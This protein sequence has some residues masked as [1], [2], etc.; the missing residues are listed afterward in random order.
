MELDLPR[1][2]FCRDGTRRSQG[3]SLSGLSSTVQG[4]KIKSRRGGTRHSRG[5]TL[6]RVRIYGIQAR[7]RPKICSLFLENVTS[8]IVRLR[9]WRPGRHSLMPVL[10]RVEITVLFQA[11]DLNATR[12]I[13]MCCCR[14]IRFS[15]I[16]ARS[17]PSMLSN[18][19]S[20]SRRGPS[21]MDT[22]SPAENN[23]L[24]STQ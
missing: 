15:R 23:D 12:G 16:T 19:A 17:S 11:M 20:R 22:G 10:Y 7:Y 21:L 1:G 5:A 8:H 3:Q 18:I 4:Q 14:C 2:K 6:L 24:L 13:F 9:F